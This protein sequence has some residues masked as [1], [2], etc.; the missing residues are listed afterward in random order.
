MKHC[1]MCGSPSGR[2]KFC[3]TCK[4]EKDRASAIVSQ[5]AKKLKLLLK[6]RRITPSGFE[7]FLLYVEHITRYG[8]VLMKYKTAEELRKLIVVNNYKNN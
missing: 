2:C 4:I 8:K 3:S 5:N 7:K 1:L 6:T